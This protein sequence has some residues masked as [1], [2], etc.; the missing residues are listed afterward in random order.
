MPGKSSYYI[1]IS[2]FV[3]FT[4]CE[5]FASERDYSEAHVYSEIAYGP[6]ARNKLDMYLPA[7]RTPN[8][9][10]IILLHGGFWYSGDK[11]ETAQLASFFQS[12]GFAAA[13]INYRLTDSTQTTIHP[14][15]VTDIGMA[16]A[17]ISKRTKDWGNSDQKFALVGLSAGAH[18]ALL[19]SYA[20]NADNKVRTVVSLAGPSDFRD[21]RMISPLQA[22][23]LEW[24]LGG[25][26][27]TKPAAYAQAS[28][29][30]QV[31][32]TSVS[33]LLFHGKLDNVVPYQQSVDLKSKLDQNGVKSKLV[34]YENTG[35]GL[36]TNANREAFLADCLAWLIENT[37]K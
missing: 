7:N 12:K 15:Q 28:P 34:L 27:V 18:L 9:P 31:K 20:Y 33:T 30:A 5:K 23:A 3:L 37:K 35:H 2:L 21:T 8:T 10:V 32:T 16:I 13:T 11:Q 6:H 14:A 1:L 17:F 24:L 26:P 36:I 19:Y 4:G 25:T 22:K 29:Q